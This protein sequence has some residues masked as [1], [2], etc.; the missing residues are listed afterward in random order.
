MKTAASYIKKKYDCYKD[1]SEQSIRDVCHIWCEVIEE[2]QNDVKKEYE[3][4]LRWIPVEEKK[5][6]N[7]NCQIL[8]KKEHENFC[9]LRFFHHESQFKLICSIHKYTHWCSFL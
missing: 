5:P 6:E 3:E 7:Y 1:Y 4:K 9:D 8:V 2:A